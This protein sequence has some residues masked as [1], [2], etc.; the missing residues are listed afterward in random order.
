MRAAERERGVRPE[1]LL[2]INRLMSEAIC[3]HPA[4]HLPGGN[5][6]I[7]QSG[8][9][10]ERQRRSGRA[11][12]LVFTSSS[13]AY[14]PRS[15]CPAFLLAGPAATMSKMLYGMTTIYAPV[16]HPDIIGCPPT[17]HCMRP[18]RECNEIGSSIFFT[19]LR[20]I[21]LTSHFGVHKNMRYISYSGHLLHLPCVTAIFSEH[22]R[23]TTPRFSPPPW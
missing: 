20:A 10:Q 23:L 15:A 17:V 1:G 11:A 19:A 13:L 2:R 5:Q 7:R 12:I 3:T 18:I 6:T 9:A 8:A 4:F 16:C 14:P 21:T 22:P